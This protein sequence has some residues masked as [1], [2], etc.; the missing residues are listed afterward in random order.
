MWGAGREKN[1]GRDLQ[2]THFKLPT[3][4]VAQQQQKNPQDTHKNKK[5][6]PL[7]RKRYGQKKFVGKFPEET[8]MLNLLDRV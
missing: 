3:V 1:G 4:S 6:W 8:Q 7:H 5:V 2:K